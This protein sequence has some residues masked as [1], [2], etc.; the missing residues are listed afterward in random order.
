[1]EGYVWIGMLLLF[2]VDFLLL[3]GTNRLCGAPPGG[4]RVALA[5]SLGAG[6]FGLCMVAG[7]SFLGHWAWRIVFLILMAL[8]AF[9]MHKELLH[10]ASVFGL[11]Q[12]A[13]A[14][15][16]AGDGFW[17]V[18]LAALVIFLLCMAGKAGPGK[19]YMP[20]CIT[21]C[22]RH[23]ELMAL[24]DT[25]N[26]L[27]DPISGRPVIV[28]DADAAMRLLDLNTADLEHPIE[29]MTSGKGKG[30]RLIPYSAVGCP[31]GLLL[32]L[33]ADSVT[34]DGKQSNHIVAFAPQRFGQGRQFQ[35][36]AGGVV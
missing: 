31:S 15:I 18:T 21:H 28:A 3:L 33:R 34:V 32:G 13:L 12:L 10:R 16:T 6:H 8:V 17:T 25:G 27:T 9:G 30:L 29:T 35:A 24:L 11:L 26:T 19:Q 4:L 23:L 1:M 2:M 5:S 22:G 36:L 14:G 20:V 7:F